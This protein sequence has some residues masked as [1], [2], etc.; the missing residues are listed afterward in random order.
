M[1]NVWGALET[2]E[3]SDEGTRDKKAQVD[4]TRKLDYY[5]NSQYNELK[6]Y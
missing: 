6:L 3:V 1:L 5:F 4:T 2:T